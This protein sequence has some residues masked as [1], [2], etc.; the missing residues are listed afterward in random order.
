[1][2]S[3]RLALEGIL[4]VAVVSTMPKELPAS[5]RSAPQWIW[6]WLRESALAFASLRGK[7]VV[8]SPP[9]TPKEGV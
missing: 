8:S 5:W 2:S 4:G 1:M 6:T 9:Q 7:S 3:E